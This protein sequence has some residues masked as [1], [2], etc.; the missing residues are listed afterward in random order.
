MSKAEKEFFEAV[1]NRGEYD[2]LPE[3]FYDRIIQNTIGRLP[4]G[5]VIIDVGCGSGAW[6]ARILER[7]HAV[8]GIDVSKGMIRNARRL[9]K[10]RRKDFFGVCGHAENLPFRHGAID[11]VFYGFSLHHVPNIPSALREVYRCLKPEGSVILVEPN[12]SNPIRLLSSVAGKLFD[13]TKARSFQSPAERPLKVSL[14]NKVLSGCGFR[15]IEVSMDFT[16]VRSRSGGRDTIVT[17][18]D[19]LLNLASRL[20]PS[21]C[22]GVNFIVMA[23]TSVQKASGSDYNKRSP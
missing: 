20:L 3:A 8:I 19:L 18:R 22:G 16:I 13:R 5:A 2:V 23:R 1:A 11:C 12:G 17:T 21:V 9:F 4:S 6:S 14:V 7:G 15:V 10:D